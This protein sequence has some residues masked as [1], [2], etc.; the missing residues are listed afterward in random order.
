MINKNNYKLEYYENLGFVINITDQYKD[1]PTK[2]IKKI[3]ENR[4]FNMKHPDYGSIYHCRECYLGNGF[5]LAYSFLLDKIIC[6][7]VL[8]KLMKD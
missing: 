3:C 4:F 2:E 6:L 7:C 1:V 8:I 5:L